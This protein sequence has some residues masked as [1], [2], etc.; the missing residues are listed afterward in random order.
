MRRR[1]PTCGFVLARFGLSRLFI[2]NTHDTLPPRRPPVLAAK[3]GLGPSP[4]KSHRRT[5]SRDVAGDV[6]CSRFT[7]TAWH[8][9]MLAIVIAFAICEA[10]FGCFSWRLGPW[11]VRHFPPLPW[12]P[13]PGFARNTRVRECERYEGS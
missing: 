9:L 7:T 6:H 13:T 3:S 5:A 4:S 1:Q 11:Q 8:G 2:R 12:F 10:T